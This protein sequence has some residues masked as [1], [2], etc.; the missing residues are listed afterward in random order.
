MLDLPDLP[1]GFRRFHPNDVHLT[2]AFL[3]GCGESAATAAV[4]AL[5]EQLRRAEYTPME[6]SLGPVVPMGARRAYSALSALL[7]EGRDRTAEYLAAL[8]D[9]LCA[10]ASAKLDDR[11]PKP[12]VTLAR[13]LR[14]A[15]STQRGAGLLWAAELTLDTVRLKLD[16]I[17]LYTWNEP[18]TEQQF[19]IV[20][21]RALG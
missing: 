11:T 18:R 7:G 9:P 16:R 2:L 6:I 8:R 5:D 17:A 15:S 14:K 4:A 13:P 3:G 1:A 10:A 20:T 19:R 21:E 12:H